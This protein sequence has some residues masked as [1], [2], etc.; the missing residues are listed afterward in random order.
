MDRL[1][2]AFDFAYG[3]IPHQLSGQAADALLIGHRGVYEHPDVL[4]NTLPAFDIAV[5]HGGGIEFDLHLTRDQVVVVHHDR[6]LSR[7]HGL[8]HAVADLSFAQLQEVAPAV[9]SLDEVLARYGHRCPHYF[10]EPKVQSPSDMRKLIQSV[11]ESLGRHRLTRYTTLLSTDSQMLDITRQ[12]LPEMAKAMVFFVDYRAALAY[13]KRHQDTGLAGWYA[14]FPSSQ[15]AFLERRGLHIGVGQIDYGNTYRHF[16]NQG[17]RYHFT[18]RIDRLVHPVEPLT[19][20]FSEQSS[21]SLA[22]LPG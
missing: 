4:E 15:R 18:N 3:L 20:P 21:R 1:Q 12:S 13:A 7:V 22:G 8:P 11:G 10:M 14:T 2:W 16:R 17:Y 5:A 9:P 6:T 19:L